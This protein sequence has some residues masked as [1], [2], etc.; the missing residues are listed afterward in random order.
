MSCAAFMFFYFGLLVFTSYVSYIT[1]KGILKNIAVILKMLMVYHG[2]AKLINKISYLL[3]LVL[4]RPVAMP[5][6]H[7]LISF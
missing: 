7:P 4:R 6:S 2:K 3:P 1:E 5:A